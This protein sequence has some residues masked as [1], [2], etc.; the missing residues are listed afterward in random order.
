MHCQSGNRIQHLSAQRM[1]HKSILIFLVRLED[2]Y[3]DNPHI[4]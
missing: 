3:K 1:K 4:L 2:S